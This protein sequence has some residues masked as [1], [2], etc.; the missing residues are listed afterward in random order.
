M[1]ISIIM[2]IM[3][4]ISI[5]KVIIITTSRIWSIAVVLLLQ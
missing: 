5:M 3:I 1:K 2:I 4:I